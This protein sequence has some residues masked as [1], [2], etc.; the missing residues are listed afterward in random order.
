MRPGRPVLFG[1][2]LFD[3]FPGGVSR[4]GGAPLNVAVHL[5]RLGERPLL[6]SRVG[7]DDA[8]SR[9]LAELERFGVDTRAVQIDAD[10]PTGEVRVDLADG[11]PHFTILEP[12]AWDAI[13]ARV[14]RE[15]VQSVAPALLYHGVLAARSVPSR[16]ALMEVR[17]ALPDRIFVDVNLRSPWTP[18]QRALELCRGAAWLKVNESELA[19]LSDLTGE[20]CE[21]ANARAARGLLARSG[22]KRLVVTLGERGAASYEAGSEWTAVGAHPAAE[23][24]EANPVGAG[25]AFAAVLIL[26]HLREWP[27]A[28]ALERATELAAA[29]CSLR[30]A[31]PD[32]PGW[33]G[34][35]RLQW[36]IS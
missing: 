2:I 4:L 32:D 18:L 15:A 8:G 14:A 34:A 7:T 12:R 36:G 3:S 21:A 30:G 25:D 22:A 19:A 20:P 24:A 27:L 9:A 35:F 31:L 33:H 26:A 17:A 28:S 5:A 23:A 6:V 13:D 1:E 10:Q 11:E 29:V 16:T